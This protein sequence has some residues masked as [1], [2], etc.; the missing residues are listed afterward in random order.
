MILALGSRQDLFDI[1]QTTDETGTEIEPFRV[2]CL[3]LSFRCLRGVKARA[4]LPP[5]LLQS[6]SHVVI[7]DQGGP[8]GL[9]LLM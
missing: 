7:E 6:G 8:H 3:S 9:M 4:M 1:I 2:E 5:L